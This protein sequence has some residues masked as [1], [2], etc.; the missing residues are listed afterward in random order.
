MSGLIEVFQSH[1]PQ[2]LY[3]AIAWREKTVDKVVRYSHL[4]E[5]ATY[6]NNEMLPVVC[7]NEQIRHK[8]QLHNIPVRPSV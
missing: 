8:L 7:Q 2:V 4:D 6:C 3:W 5:I 1:S